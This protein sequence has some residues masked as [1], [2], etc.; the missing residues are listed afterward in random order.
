MAIRRARLRAARVL[1]ALG[2]GALD[3]EHHSV[4]ILDAAILD[5]LELRAALA[6]LGERLLDGLVGHD[7]GTPDRF[8]GGEIADVE[9]RYGFDRRGERER[10][11]LFERD[12][13]D[14]RRVYR[15]DA[16]LLE[17]LI[18]GTWNQSVR[19]IVED[20]FLES[21]LDECGRH[22]ARPEAGNPR[23]LRVALGDA[24]DFGRHDVGRDLDRDR[25]LRRADVGEF[26]LHRGTW[27]RNLEHGPWNRIPTSMFQGPGS[28]M[29]KEGLEPPFPFGNQILS[30]ARLPV[31]PLSRQAERSTRGLRNQAR[32]QGSGLGK[33]LGVKG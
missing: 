33:A 15:L 12:V 26:G 32:A 13:L 27:N 28:G 31:P 25:L 16:P 11:T 7:A 6:Q 14:V 8:D 18:D 4:A 23:L 1:A 10:L 3:V 9:G 30:L 19:D 2:I 17:R 24:I 5:R 29:R 22:L 20:L 21:F